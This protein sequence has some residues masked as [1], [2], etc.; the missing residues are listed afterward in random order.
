MKRNGQKMGFFSLSDKGKREKSSTPPAEIWGKA[1]GRGLNAGTW[2]FLPRPQSS[3]GGGRGDCFSAMRGGGG[4]KHAPALGY[5]VALRGERGSRE[6]R[7]EIWCWSQPWKDRGT[8]GRKIPSRCGKG[9]VGIYFFLH[10]SRTPI[11][12]IIMTRYN[13]LPKGVG[14]QQVRLS[15]LLPMSPLFLESSRCSRGLAPV[16]FAPSQAQLIFFPLLS[17][18]RLCRLPAVTA[19]AG[20]GFITLTPLR[21]PRTRLAPPLSPAR[22]L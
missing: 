3:S 17:L 5:R 2:G 8:V 9:C 4:G 18:A 16:L 20:T 12:I 14:G 11:I 6:G 15:P 22:P 10:G 1:G 7:G 13:S 19:A 21:A